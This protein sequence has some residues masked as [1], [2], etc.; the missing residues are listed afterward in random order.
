MITHV[1][2]ALM[3]G[4]SF[5]S[6][7]ERVMCIDQPGGPGIVSSTHASAAYFPSGVVS[8]RNCLWYSRELARHFESS[9]LTGETPTLRF[10]WLRSFHYGVVFRVEFQEEGQPAILIWK[11]ADRDGNFDPRSNNQTH[12]I[13]LSQEDTRT[14]FTL[15]HESAVCAP[16]SEP[17]PG[18]DGATWV[19]EYVDSEQY[20]FHDEWQPRLGPVR[21]L[22]QLVIER[23]RETE[24]R[25]E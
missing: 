8:E 13:F 2:F 6:E 9:L 25:A 22:G 14:I 3:L 10:T 16:A 19:F 11:S 5:P 7:V 1:M 23:Y 12:E 20:C 18:L 4:T 15:I 17:M 24:N 21:R